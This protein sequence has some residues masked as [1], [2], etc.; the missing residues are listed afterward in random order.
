M[1]SKGL[2]Q[3]HRHK[4]QN[5]DAKEEDKHFRVHT[6]PLPRNVTAHLFKQQLYNKS[7]P[8][9]QFELSP[10]I[11]QDNIDEEMQIQ[12]WITILKGNK[13]NPDLSLIL[14]TND[15]IQH[16]INNKQPNPSIVLENEI[17]TTMFDMIT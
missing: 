8:Q 5:Y 17:M 7:S 12:Q 15:K 3:M 11:S 16:Y 1:N 6:K 10:A 9:L 2:K 14:E 13:K 4:R